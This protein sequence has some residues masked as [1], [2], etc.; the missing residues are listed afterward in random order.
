MARPCPIGR[1]QRHE[2][3]EII[4]SFRVFRGHTAAVLI[5]G[6]CPLKQ[7]VAASGV[8]RGFQPSV[9]ARWRSPKRLA[10]EPHNGLKSAS[11]STDIQPEGRAHV[12]YRWSRR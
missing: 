11:S 10:L 2:T 8:A 1:W 4:Q 3:H 12:Y 9:R 6:E 5:Q 7:T